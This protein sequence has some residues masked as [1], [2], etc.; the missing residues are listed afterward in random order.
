MRL[1]A[2]RTGTSSPQAAA[3]GQAPAWQASRHGCGQCGSCRW[4]GLPQLSCCRCAAAA[5]PAGAAASCCSCW[6]VKL[7]LH[8]P[9]WQGLLLGSPQGGQGPGWQLVGQGWL[10]LRALLQA[11]LQRSHGAAASPP[12]TP[13]C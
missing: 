4:Q 2:Q 5:W 10:Q 9:Q 1:Q 8:L 13:R 7:R 12:Q 3:W 6:Q 11:L